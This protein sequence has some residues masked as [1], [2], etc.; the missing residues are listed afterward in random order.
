MC[1]K[2]LVNRWQKRFCSR[3]CTNLWKKG[4]V[5]SKDTCFKEGSTPWNLG[6]KKTWTKECKNCK[7]QFEAYYERLKFCSIRCSSNYLHK[8]KTVS[9]STI[10]KIIET[11]KNE[12]PLYGS[13]TT[14]ARKHRSSSRWRKWRETV[15]ERDNYTCQKCETTGGYLEPHHITTVKEC[16]E[17]GDINMIYN[18]D[19]GLTLCR[20]CHMITH[21]WTIRGD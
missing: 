19:N 6:T 18:I 15:F 14:E 4:K 9:K 20:K 2:P 11:K 3:D 13:R 21:G 5:F 7:E 17:I 12:D 16:L 10:S 1:N 8:G